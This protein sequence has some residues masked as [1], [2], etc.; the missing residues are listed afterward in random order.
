MMSGRVVVRAEAVHKSFGVNEVLRGVTVELCAGEI[1]GLMGPSGSGKST[2]LH[3]LAGLLPADRGEVWFEQHE[4]AHLTEKQRSRL[5]LERMGFVFQFGDLVPELTLV[6]NVELPLRAAGTPRNKA[7]PLAL[8]LMAAL[9]I[10]DV[11]HQRTAEVSGGEAQRAAVGRALVHSPA[12]V[13]ADEPTGSLDTLAGETVLELLTG[14]A[15]ETDA[16]VLL[17]THEARVAAW[18]DREIN[19]LDGAILDGAGV[20]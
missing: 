19:L 1:L 17:V 9:G 3:I 7:R 14:I 5:R 20:R 4:L 15:R 16:G 13:F 11:A 10:A 18:A 12:V 8:D 6:E 2:L